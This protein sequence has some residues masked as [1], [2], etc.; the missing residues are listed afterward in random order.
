AASLAGNSG[1]IRTWPVKNS[2]GPVL[3]ACE[4]GR[5]IVCDVLFAS[6]ARA[7]PATAPADTRRASDKS[8]AV[9]FIVLSLRLF[10]NRCAGRCA[11]TGDEAN[12]CIVPS[13]LCRDAW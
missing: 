10:V 4:P 9:Y 1:S 5:E 3:E 6:A 8:M 7:R 12:R 13:S 11:Q 2:A